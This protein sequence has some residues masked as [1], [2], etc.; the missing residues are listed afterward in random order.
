MPAAQTILPVFFPQRVQI[1]FHIGL[2]RFI[3]MLAVGGRL[4]HIFQINAA[5]VFLPDAVKPP[6]ISSP[7][8]GTRQCAVMGQFNGLP[9]GAFDQ[10]ADDISLMEHLILQRRIRPVFGQP[11]PFPDRF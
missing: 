7:R 9:I 1:L 10:C 11:G 4:C 8:V 6:E 5:V 2:V 3:Q